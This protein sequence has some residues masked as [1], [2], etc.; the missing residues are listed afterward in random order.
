V[1]EHDTLGG[2]AC[3]WLSCVIAYAELLGRRGRRPRQYTAV[4]PEAFRAGPFSAWHAE[5]VAELQ[6][7][8]PA[9]CHKTVRELQDRRRCIQQDH[10]AQA[11]RAL[12]N[13]CGKQL[14]SAEGRAHHA[15][16]VAVVPDWERLIQ[17]ARHDAMAEFWH[18]CHAAFMLNV[19]MVVVRPPAVGSP[20]GS[21]IRINA[22]PGV[23]QTN[24]IYITNN[25]VHFTALLPD[26]A[27]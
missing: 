6:R 20:G 7:F 15:V 23:P 12:R 1:G 26:P 11:A 18:V 19:R 9:V 24:T 17:R 14:L 10:L 13:L 2:N 21:L 3:L 22:E 27:P 5:A 16:T 25:G 4:P 8:M